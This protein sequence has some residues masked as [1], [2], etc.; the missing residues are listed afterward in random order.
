MQNSNDIQEPV[1][2]QNRIDQL[3]ISNRATTKS[4]NPSREATSLRTK[5]R[6]FEEV[7]LTALDEKT[8][9][10]V[11]KRYK[12]ILR[13]ARSNK[14]D[15]VSQQ[16]L[17]GIGMEGDRAPSL[18]HRKSSD[19]GLALSDARRLF[20][21]TSDLMKVNVLKAFENYCVPYLPESCQ[22]QYLRL[23]T[24]Q[25]ASHASALNGSEVK[26]VLEGWHGDGFKRLS[27]A[28]AKNFI[29]QSH[30]A[31]Q[32]SLHGRRLGQDIRRPRVHKVFAKRP[33]RPI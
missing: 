10:D 26:L 8:M 6:K 21:D 23:I 1:V 24:S 19:L 32:N 33:Q 29:S 2:S 18:E 25:F 30:F 22:A 27:G 5:L 4:R 20:N 31:F 7:C 15:I 12:A 17:V 14:N 3:G 13:Q 11:R 16:D 9:Q 28:K